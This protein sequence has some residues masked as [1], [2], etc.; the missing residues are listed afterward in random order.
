[1]WRGPCGRDARKMEK[2]GE[3]REREEK[4]GEMR[5]REERREKREK[6][7]WLAQV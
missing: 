2:R 4:R 1:M 3:M 6:N 5:K 7:A